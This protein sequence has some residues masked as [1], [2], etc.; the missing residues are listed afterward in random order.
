MF[1]VEI[2]V[3]IIVE[4]SVGNRVVLELILILHTSPKIYHELILVQEPIL[5]SYLTWNLS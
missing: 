4:K 3:G 1:N 5:N 2:I